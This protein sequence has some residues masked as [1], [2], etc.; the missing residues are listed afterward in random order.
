MALLLADDAAVQLVFH[1][2]ELV[3][4]VLVDRRE[5]HARPLG[6]DLVDFR[7]ADH[8]ARRGRRHFDAIAHELHALA[9]LQVV[10]AIE[11][12]LVRLALRRPAS[13]TTRTVRAFVARLRDR[14][15]VA[16]LGARA[17]LVD[18]VDGLVRQEPVGDV[19]ARL[20]HGRLDAPPCV[21]STWWNDS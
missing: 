5:R 15:G 12:R 7:L 14:F 10:I 19:S 2:Q 4:L 9:A 21:Y 1:A 18:E 6:H 16:Q 17:G 11:P 8:D 20:I 3:A 13:T